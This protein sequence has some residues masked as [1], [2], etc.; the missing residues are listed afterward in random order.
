MQMPNY[1]AHLKFGERVTAQLPAALSKTIAAQHAAFELG[2]LG[3]DPLFFYKP[4]RPN[5]VR[6]E[7]VRMHR[8]SAL[9][10]VERL[11]EAVEAEQPMA[12][13]YSAGFLCHLALDSAC[14]GYVEARAAQ[15]PISH[16]A[17]EGEYDRKLMAA[18]GLDTQARDYLPRV[19]DER[20]IWAAAS[21]AFC[22]VTPEQMCRA[23]RAMCFYTGFLARSCGNWRGKTIGF[24]S[25]LLPIPSARGIALNLQ[26]N[27][28]SVESSAVLDRLLSRAVSGTAEQI[29]NFFRAADAGTPT[30]VWFARDF[31]GGPPAAEAAVLYT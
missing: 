15:G 9:P 21:R 23:Y 13:G 18:D 26:P 19:P 25:R 7:G 11:R 2:C 8:T 5:A 20:S 6:R 14:H 31:K 3:P 17:M 22:H 27:P 10:A 30:P 29:A 24:V 12:V 28:A 4:V 1:Y 16:M